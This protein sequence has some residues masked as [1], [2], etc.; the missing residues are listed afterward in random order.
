MR[1]LVKRT[2]QAIALVIVFPAAL[3]AGFGR[4]TPGFDLF[5]HVFAALPGI[6]GNFL[7][8]AYYRL[9]LASC[10]QDT[11][12]AFG[13]FF[14]RQNASVGRNVSIGS[15]CIIGHATIGEG[16]QISSHVQIP[17][18]KHDHPRDSE[19]RFLPGVEGE[20]QIGSYCFIAASAVV[21]ANVGDFSTIGA[22]SVVVHDI[23]SRTIAVGNPARV[24]KPSL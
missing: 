10:S 1:I 15:Y 4:F 8:A 6:I 20:V 3:L 5:A 19:G 14:S 22:G 18:G 9:T 23:P 7:R 16:S 13:T 17:S 11:T 12:I 21:L 2:V 24:I